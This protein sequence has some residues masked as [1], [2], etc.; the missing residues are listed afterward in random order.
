MTRILLALTLI[1]FCGIARS[2]DELANELPRIKPLDAAAAL[3]AFKIHEGFRL[4][5][6]AVEPLVTDPVAACYDA[7][8]RLYVVEMRGYPYPENSPTGYVRRLEDVDLVLPR[9]E[10][11]PRNA[12]R[13]ARPRRRFQ[14]EAR[15]RTQRRDDVGQ[16]RIDRERL[17]CGAASHL[18]VGRCT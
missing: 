16:E 18:T 11:R 3:K 12:R 2:D 4:D 6:V 1:S 8:G 9:V 15:R 10:E 7:D 17:Q 5:P 13:L 14:D